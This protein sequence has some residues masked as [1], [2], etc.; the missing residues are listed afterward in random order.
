VVWDDRDD[1]LTL[2]LRNGQ[3]NIPEIDVTVYNGT[4]AIEAPSP[5]FGV[6]VFLGFV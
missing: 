5:S 2:Q 6:C 4:S 1:A 3:A